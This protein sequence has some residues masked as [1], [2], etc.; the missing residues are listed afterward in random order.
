LKPSNGG[1]DESA[2]GHERNA[3]G[4]LRIPHPLPLPA[5]LLKT[6]YSGSTVLVTGASRGFGA[7]F[8]E[9]LGSLG[10]RVLLV[11][12]SADELMAVAERVRQRGGTT[13]VLVSDLSTP[14]AADLLAARLS[15]HDET[16]D[17]LINNAGY[18]IV[19]PFLDVSAEDVEGIAMLNVVALT[20]LTRQLV[21]GMVERGRG[22]VLNLSSL[23]A[24]V[25]APRLAV[26]AATKAYVLS[27]TDALHAELR[28]TGVHATALCPG[29]VQTGFGERAGIN[30]Q[31]YEGKMPISRVVEAGLN[32]LARNRRRVVPGWTTKLQ[33][34]ASGWVPSG[35]TL[36][37][38]EAV[39]RR[40][41]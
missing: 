6:F 24:F 23:S 30:P 7:A 2:A 10:A 4:V 14:G 16:V 31:F 25:P 13:A 28:D 8:A 40:A 12:R 41:R 20:S 26:Y 36:R 11:A 17:V 29:L 37:V 32:G 1:I 34:A 22:G 27:L 35:I 38:T 5:T 21:P 33:A 18:G 39:L 19:G 15:E 3:G 9:H